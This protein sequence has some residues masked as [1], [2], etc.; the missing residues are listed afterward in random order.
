MSKS[1]LNPEV[2]QSLGIAGLSENDQV[3]FLSEHADDIFL[4]SMDR[5]ETSLEGE[6]LVQVQLFLSED[7]EPEEVINHLF[8]NFESFKEVLKEVVSEIS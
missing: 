7:P 3:A 1:I 6:D 2:L 5:F 8:E 4:T